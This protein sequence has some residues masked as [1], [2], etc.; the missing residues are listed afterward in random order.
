MPTPTKEFGRSPGRTSALLA[1]SE[2]DWKGRIAVWVAC[3]VD[4]SGNATTFL[5]DGPM[6]GR[7]SSGRTKLEVAPESTTMVDAFRW[8]GWC[9]PMR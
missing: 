1:L 7:F 3:F 5:L 2:R 6:I 4:P 9:L 8:K